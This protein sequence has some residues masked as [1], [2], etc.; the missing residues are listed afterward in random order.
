VLLVLHKIDGVIFGVME[1]NV[2]SA[3]K[4]KQLQTKF[5]LTRSV[6]VNRSV[7]FLPPFTSFSFYRAVSRKPH[8]R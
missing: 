1:D 5:R 2:R 8:I 6:G 3:T 4:S 7:F